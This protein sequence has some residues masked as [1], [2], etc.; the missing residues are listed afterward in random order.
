[1]SWYGCLLLSQS[2]MLFVIK[3][4]MI[5]EDIWNKIHSKLSTKEAQEEAEIF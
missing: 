1:M 5:L 4:Y 2:Y 3:I